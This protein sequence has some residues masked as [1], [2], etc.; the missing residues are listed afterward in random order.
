LKAVAQ[1]PEILGQEGAFAPVPE[2]AED[3]RVPQRIEDRPR[4]T[5]KR[6]NYG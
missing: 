1:K 5:K 3:L 2:F 4:S 6:G